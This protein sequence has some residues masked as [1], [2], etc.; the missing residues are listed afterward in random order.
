MLTPGEYTQLTGRAGRRGIDDIGYAVVT[1]SPWVSFAQVVALASARSYELTSSF[2]PNY[3]M[4]ANLVQRYEPEEARHLLNLSFAQYRSDSET[5]Q[6]EGRLEQLRANLADVLAAATCDR[7]DIWA[8]RRSDLRHSQRTAGG[9]GAR[10]P[11]SAVAA[12]LGKLRPG[13]VIEV[14]GVVVAVV[15][16]S[17]RRGGGAR[18]AVIRGDGR[19]DVL[20][21]SDFSAPPRVLATLPLPS[22]YDPSDA[23]FLRA[24]ARRLIE[25]GL[26]G[27]DGGERP[28]GRRRDPLDDEQSG[29][30]MASGDPIASCPDLRRHLRAADR[31]ERIEG[32]IGRLERRLSGRRRS[33]SGQLDRFLALLEEWGYVR[34]W[35][36]TD[37]GHLLS[38]LYHEQDLLVVECLDAGLLDDLEG[39][40]LAA[41]ASAFT[42]EARAR[43]QPEGQ[44]AA[45]PELA[46]RFSEIERIWRRLTQAE[47]AADLP[48]TRMP[49][50][51]FMGSAKAWASG[52]SLSRIMDRSGLSGGDFVRNVKQLA[53]LLHQLGDLHDHPQTAAVAGRMARE[54]VRGVVAASSVLENGRGEA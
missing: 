53:D 38:A 26:A 6:L 49:E 27:H 19:K 1:W 40:S 45:G 17:R 2:R 24:T 35:S 11:R 41:L 16:S 34:G 42:F 22:P 54:I 5:V 8:Y 48:T 29:A 14:G 9:Q 18:L 46:E 23:G 15:A 7:G 51:G 33:L 12:S 31:A 50:P 25:S 20:G 43:A 28:G 30:R 52:R 39:P 13:E 36:L 10:H 3:N 37:K 4:T 32:E 44:L 21:P 47:A